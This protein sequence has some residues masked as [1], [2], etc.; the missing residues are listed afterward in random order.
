MRRFGRVV[1]DPDRHPIPLVAG[2][3]RDPSDPGFSPG[4]SIGRTFQGMVHG[5]P[6]QVDHRIAEPLDDRPVQPR[7]LADD[8]QLARESSLVGS[9]YAAPAPNADEQF[10][11]KYRATFGA[12]PSSLSSLAYDAVSLVALLSQGAPYHRFTQSALMDPN[13]FA[14][15][16]GI[17]RFTA[18]GTSERG[19]AVMEITSTGP[20]VV[21]PA[22]T[23][24]LGKNS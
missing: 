21:S 15:V 8:P 17:F 3:Q 23:T 7:L 20:T 19:L 12:T 10:A 14:G 1:L 9:W 11:T 6:D 4:E 5:V 22:P 18:D 2:R 16:N 24:F 13:G